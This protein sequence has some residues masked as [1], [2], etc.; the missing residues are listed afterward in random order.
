MKFLKKL[1]KSI[2]LALYWHKAINAVYKG[3]FKKASIWMK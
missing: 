2:I 3:D 1:T